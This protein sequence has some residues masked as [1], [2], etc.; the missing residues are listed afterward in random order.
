[1]PEVLEAS[2]G[3]S[4]S[5]QLRLNCWAYSRCR[6][7]RR[8]SLDRCADGTHQQADPARVAGIRE[9]DFR[10]A[11]GATAVGAVG[12][13]DARRT[14][15]PGGEDVAHAVLGERP[16][17]PTSS[18]AIVTAA[19]KPDEGEK[20]R[21]WTSAPGVGT[22]ASLV[23][24]KPRPDR[25]PPT[26][27]SVPSQSTSASG[28]HALEPPGDVD[29][30]AGVVEAFIGAYAST[31]DS[32]AVAGQGELPFPGSA[33]NTP[34]TPGEPVSWDANTPPRLPIV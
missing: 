24:S 19:P 25:P 29:S 7:H 32:L 30:S 16:S 11:P 1:M 22:W 20:C 5:G 12:K 6:R 4:T 13:V 18:V 34:S 26:A 2:Q 31:R 15:E 9:Q 21:Y 10:F 8:P 14:V 33:S 27:G 28:R 17:P 3:L 23:S